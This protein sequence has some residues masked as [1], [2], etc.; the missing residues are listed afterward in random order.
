MC[1]FVLPSFPL[2]F[3][4]F[5]ITVF[6]YFWIFWGLLCCLYW[7]GGRN[8]D[9]RIVRYT[10]KKLPP[11]LLWEPSERGIKKQIQTNQKDKKY[12]QSI[13][14]ICSNYILESYHKHCIS[15]CWTFAPRG[16]TVSRLLRASVHIFVNQSIQNLIVPVFL[17]KDTFVKCSWFVNIE[18][19]A[20]STV[21][22]A[23]CSLSNTHTFSLKHIVAFL[24]L[25][26]DS[27]SAPTWR[28]F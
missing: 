19:A 22:H 17:F 9:N 11:P 26:L 15:E 5:S 12:I 1:L 25:T 6:Y 28:T 20:N 13:L 24:C 23:W 10:W 2:L 8:R 14:M 4:P 16:N 7:A 27:T 18:I 21:T 3:L